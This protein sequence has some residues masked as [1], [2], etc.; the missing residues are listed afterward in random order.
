MCLYLK[1]KKG[2]WE[3]YVRNWVRPHRDLTSTYFKISNAFECSFLSFI[4]YFLFFIFFAQTPIIYAK[5]TIATSYIL[6]MQTAAE[7]S[8]GYLFFTISL[9]NNN[10]NTMRRKHDAQTFIVRRI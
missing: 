10:T 3:Y 7:S 6:K 5:T 4:F 1:I 8:S 2:A 9:D